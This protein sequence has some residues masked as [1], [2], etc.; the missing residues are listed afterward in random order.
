LNSE[1]QDA[2]IY[3]GDILV[4]DVNGVVCIPQSMAEKAL[5]LIQSQVDADD[6]VAADIQ[7]GRAVAEA[8]KE[9]R[10]GVKQP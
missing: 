7:K 10:A 5:D 4:G 2:V 8:M 1:D 3:P 9:H 6:K